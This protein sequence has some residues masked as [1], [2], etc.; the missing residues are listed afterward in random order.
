MSSSPE[1]AKLMQLRAVSA[2]VAFVYE[3]S[4]HASS[5]FLLKRSVTDS[6]TMIS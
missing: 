1:I 3:L 2:T 4:V 5:V 6:Y